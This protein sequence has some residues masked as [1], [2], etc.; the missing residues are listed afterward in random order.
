M[1]ALP[2][3][4]SGLPRWR[5][6]A[7]AGV[8]LF[9]GALMLFAFYDAFAKQMV[10]THSPVVMNLSR[11]VCISTM[12]LGL[13]LHHGQLRF[14]RQPHQGLLLARSGMLALV[15]TCFM[16]A[17][18]TMP[19]AEATAI[20]FTAPLLMVAL[21]PALLGET[22]RRAQ[23]LAVAGGFA[24][25][26]L[27]VRPGHDLPLAGTLLMAVAATGYALFQ[28]FTRRLSGLVPAPVQFAHM[29]FVCLAVTLVLA[30]L[31]PGVEIP[32]WPEALVLLAGGLVSGSAQLLLLA[33][34][35]RTQASTLAPLNY[36]QL[37]LAV[38]IS[39]FWFQR[40]PDGLAMAGMACIAVA[41]VYLARSAATPRQRHPETA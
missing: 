40:P 37:L 22:V 2:A 3:S 21:A 29:A 9:L 26:L 34:F 11:Y 16:T 38:L 19:L 13:L 39:A 15:A 35:S 25:M 12:G 8:L 18:V 30:A 24:G 1:S 20:Y 7:G 14:W 5:S 4:A 17:L 32:P 28:V 36:V 10:A 41:G 33:A 31:A 27:I 23:W 6:G